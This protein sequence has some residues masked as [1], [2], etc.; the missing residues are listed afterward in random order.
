VN[1]HKAMAIMTRAEL[2]VLAESAL[3]TVA[4]ARHRTVISDD[5]R[6]ACIVERDRLRKE[7]SDLHE[8]IAQER[9]RPPPL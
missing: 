6:R 8:T 9:D 5:V 4:D 3:E 2:L 1:K 7:L